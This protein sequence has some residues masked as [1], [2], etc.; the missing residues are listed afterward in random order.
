MPRAVS[1][2]GGGGLGMPEH[3]NRIALQ[4]L[5]AGWETGERALAVEHLS[6]LQ[7]QDIALLV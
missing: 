6:V 7:L 1:G 3:P 4:T 2:N 5:L